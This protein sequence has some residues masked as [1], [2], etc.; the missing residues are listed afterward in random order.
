VLVQSVARRFLVLNRLAK[1]IKSNA[2]LKLAI[3]T[4]SHFRY[5]LSNFI[6]MYMFESV[7]LLTILMQ[8]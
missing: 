4:Q 5:V 2:G 1:K 7:I 6:C 3:W 8:S